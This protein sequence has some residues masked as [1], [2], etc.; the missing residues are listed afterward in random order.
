MNITKQNKVLEIIC[1]SL[2]IICTIFI[3]F[4][5]EPWLDEFQAWGISKDS[6]YNILF[7]IPHFEGHPPLWH[8]ILKCFSYFNANPEAGL[9]IANFIFIY[10]A[11]WLLLFKSPFPR[12]V[13]LLIPFTFFIFY[14]TAIVSRPYSIMALALFAAACF[15]KERNTKPF[16]Y[17]GALILLSLS[18]A[19]GM[20]FTAGITAAWFIEILIKEKMSFIGNFFKDSRIKAMFLIFCVCLVL[21]FMIFPDKAAGFGTQFSEIT[22]LKIL[23]LFFVLPC[24]S[25]ITDVCYSVPKL[26][27]INLL[28]C[29]LGVFIYFLYFYAFRFYKVLIL[30]FV[31]YFT[32]I[33]ASYYLHIAAHHIS[34]L[35]IFYIFV[36]WCGLSENYR[37]IPVKYKKFFSCIVIYILLVQLYWSVYSYIIDY[38][39]D[40]WF[41]RRTAEYI[42]SNNLERFNILCAWYIRHN[43]VNKETGGLLPYNIAVEKNQYEDFIKKYEKKTIINYSMQHLPVCFIPYFGRNI[44]YAFN[45]DRRER[46]YVI[47]KNPDGAENE[48]VKN[49]I[50]ETGLPEI[51]IGNPQDLAFV[52]PQEELKN[53]YYEQLFEFRGMKAWKGRKFYLYLPVYAR[54]DIY[55]KVSAR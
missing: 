22:S 12:A 55:K 18:C 6:L 27:S 31:P 54:D 49:L 45:I 3:S 50:Y 38:K 26:D 35:T 30:F 43:Y 14:Q 29:L 48:A 25:L 39:Y 42:K 15:Y 2:F 32:F 47:W 52:F 5:H 7:V 40:Y 16:K 13:K 8:L 37:E 33:A 11:V 46:Q 21:S 10:P 34:I 1:F 4:F 51:M 53:V 9:A 24:D 20:I 41:S 17:A 23:Y 19:F 44:F 28:Y 36:L